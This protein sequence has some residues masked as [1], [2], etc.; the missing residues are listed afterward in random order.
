MTRNSLNWAR[1][2]VILHSPWSEL[3]PEMLLNRNGNGRGKLRSSG[4]PVDR[5]DVPADGGRATGGNG[6]VPATRYGTNN[7]G[8]QNAGSQGPNQT[9]AVKLAGEEKSKQTEA[10]DRA[11][12]KEGLPWVVVRG[13]GRSGD[14]GK[15]GVGG[16]RAG[17]DGTG[18]K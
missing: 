5:D 18:G 9:T 13:S 17:D 11:G 2:S 1:R 8:G 7:R 6:S 3:S 15:E 14:Y 4:S 16:T 12:E 10:E